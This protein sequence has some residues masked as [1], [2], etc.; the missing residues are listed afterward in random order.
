MATPST[1]SLS[2]NDSFG[3]IIHSGKNG[4]VLDLDIE[5]V[6]DRFRQHGML[7]LRGFRVTHT[8]FSE[9]TARFLSQHQLHDSSH[10]TSDRVATVYAGQHAIVY[11]AELSATPLRPDIIWFHCVTPAHRDGET[12]VCDGIRVFHSLRPETRE[13]FLRKR[14]RFSSSLG[15]EMSKTILRIASDPALRAELEQGNNYRYEADSQGNVVA[16]YT[17]DAAQKIPHGSEIAFANSLI[18]FSRLKAVTFEDG[19]D[20]PKDIIREVE[21]ACA[22]R[23]VLLKWEKGD[24]AMIDNWRCM[25]GRRAFVGERVIHSV[26]GRANF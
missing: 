7:L 8:S 12:T 10:G 17:T 4:H 9:F 6:K 16:E 20:I 13:V 19:S 11:H 14:L 22:A 24:I 25:H 26:F 18:P 1:C 5:L 21:L 2:S 3:L 23:T 15:P